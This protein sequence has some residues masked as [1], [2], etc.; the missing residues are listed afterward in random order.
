VKFR[1]D[2]AAIRG[3]I[4]PVITPFTDD[5]ALDLESLRGLVRWQLES[6]SHG[7]RWRRTRCSRCRVERHLVAG[8][9]AL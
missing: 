4:V 1:S 2:P 9:V 3:S 6:G 7:D 8:T 5:G